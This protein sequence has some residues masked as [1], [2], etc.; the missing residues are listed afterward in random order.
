MQALTIVIYQSESRVAQA[1]AGVLSQHFSAVYVA[2]SFR[3]VHAAVP[4]FRADVAILDIEGANVSEIERLHREY[5]GLSIVCTHRVAD[6]E[7][8][9]TVL[10][11]GAS[12]MCPT[13]D[14]QGIVLAAVRQRSSTHAAA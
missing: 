9:A 13:C 14:T 10:N 6:E 4:R 8:W 11:A 2:D 7:M 12:D 3:E 1:L 5:P